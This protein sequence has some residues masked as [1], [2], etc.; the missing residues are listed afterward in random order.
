MEPDQ[1][2][3]LSMGELVVLRSPAE[4]WAVPGV[5]TDDS[6]LIQEL[7]DDALAMV[8]GVAELPEGQ[9]IAGEPVEV[10]VASGSVMGWTFASAV[11]H[12]D[13]GSEVGL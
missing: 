3:R 4:L 9:R 12:V 13:D 10:F 5:I 8:L 6:L 11:F 2:R 1:A 7:A